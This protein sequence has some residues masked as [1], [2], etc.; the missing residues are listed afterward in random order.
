MKELLVLGAGT[1]GTMTVN[2]LRR[3]LA[4]GE[5]HITIVDADDVHHYQ[6]GYLFVPF[7]TYTPEQVTRSRH[8]TLP[9]G[10]N[11]VIGEVDRGVHTRWR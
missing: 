4:V 5:W 3:S 10:V 1:A 6:P 7:G 2:K 8:T 11:F 9:D